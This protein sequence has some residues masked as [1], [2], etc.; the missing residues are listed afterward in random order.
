MQQDCGLPTKHYKWFILNS[1][2]KCYARDFSHMNCV[3]LLPYLSVSGQ[4]DLST[5]QSSS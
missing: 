2:C 5:L 1:I 3:M 4:L